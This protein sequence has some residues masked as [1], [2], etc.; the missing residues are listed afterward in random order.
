MINGLKHKDFILNILRDG[1][2]HFSR[3]FVRDS[4]GGGLLLEYRKR[5][6]ELRKDGYVIQSV[7]I[8]KRPGYILKFK[9][10]LFRN[11]LLTN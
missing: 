2:P 3:E 5:L 9:E 11:D 6:S 1:K 10:D 8:D 7:R 4:D